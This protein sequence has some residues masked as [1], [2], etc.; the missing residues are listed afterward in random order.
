[1][2][3]RRNTV[4]REIDMHTTINYPESPKWAYL[5]Q[6]SVTIP[7]LALIPLIIWVI[8]DHQSVER[9]AIAGLSFRLT[10]SAWIGVSG[11]LF[12]ALYSLHKYFS[13]IITEKDKRIAE[14][15]DIIEHL[16]ESKIE[17]D[18]S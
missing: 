17:K 13:Y 4:S 1:M 3:K 16:K 7:A 14:L 15:H 2:T 6:W 5:C 10:T 9:A 8:K 18:E 12:I 11:I